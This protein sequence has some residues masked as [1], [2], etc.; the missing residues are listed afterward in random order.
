MRLLNGS[1]ESHSPTH[2]SLNIGRRGEERLGLPEGLAH[3]LF[4]YTVVLD[5]NSSKEMRFSVK[6]P[7]LTVEESR[8]QTSLL[9][10]HRN[11]MSLAEFLGRGILEITVSRKAPRK[12]SA[13]NSS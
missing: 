5:L 10:L 13:S 2:C 11:S 3:Y 12:Y 7:L 4:R 8:C 1:H 6:A 9:Y